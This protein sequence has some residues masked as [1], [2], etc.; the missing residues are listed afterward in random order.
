[1]QST[2]GFDWHNEHIKHVEDIVPGHEDKIIE[3]YESKYDLFLRKIIEWTKW[4]IGMILL[5]FS[6]LIAFLFSIAYVFFFY[7][8]LFLVKYKV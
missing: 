2:Y 7:L 8:W 1:M 3:K 6:I 4:M 5:L